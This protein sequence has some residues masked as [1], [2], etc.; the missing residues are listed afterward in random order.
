MEKTT[1]MEKIKELALKYFNAFE[2]SVEPKNGL[3]MDIDSNNTTLIGAYCKITHPFFRGK[4]FTNAFPGG[5]IA[6][7]KVMDDS[8]EFEKEKAKL[9][10]EART[11]LSEVK[12]PLDIF[13]LILSQHQLQFMKEGIQDTNFRQRPCLFQGVLFPAACDRDK[14]NTMNLACLCV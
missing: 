8:A 14:T 9:V 11:A 7:Y 5:E 12:T 4:L 3:P 10:N 13:A 6:L 1:N 2:I